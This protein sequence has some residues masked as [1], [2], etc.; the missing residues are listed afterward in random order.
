MVLAGEEKY[1]G[2]LPADSG[3]PV[4]SVRAGGPVLPKTGNP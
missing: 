1:T 4:L 2:V 3:L